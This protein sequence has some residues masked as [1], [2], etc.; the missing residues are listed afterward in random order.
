MTN[1]YTD[2]DYDLRTIGLKLKPHWNRHTVV[3]RV[4][5]VYT[6]TKKLTFKMCHE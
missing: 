4:G 5:V 6:N 3:G 1:I 2:I